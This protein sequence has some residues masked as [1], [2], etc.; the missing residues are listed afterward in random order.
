M[1]RDSIMREL[2]GIVLGQVRDALQKRSSTQ[3]GAPNDEPPVVA[4][5]MIEIRSD[6]SRT[7]ARGALND[8]RTGESAQ[9]HAEGKTP[10]DLMISLAG[11]LLALPASIGQAIFRRNGAPELKKETKPVDTV[12]AGSRTDKDSAGPR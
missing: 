11:S 3:V 9:V 7:I 12:T 10:G 1:A 8:L 2:S 6:G 4:Q 5:L